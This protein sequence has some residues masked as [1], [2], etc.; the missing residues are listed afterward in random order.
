MDSRRIAI[1]VS[2]WFPVPPQGY[3]GIEL[4]AYNLGRELSSRGHHVTI[5]G[6][7]G[8]QGPYE[9]L[10]L[11]PES[12][13]RQLGTRDEL[14]RENLFLY[15]AYETVRRR[16]FDVI[17]DNSGMNGILVAAQSR[18]Q[19]P[20]VAT[21]HGALSE[22]EGDFLNAVDRQVHLVSIS[23]AQ[24]ALV[25]SVEWRGM[26]HNAINPEEYT[27]ITKPEEKQDYLVELARISPEKGQDVA[28]EIAKRLRMPLV[29]AGK[30]DYDARRYRFEARTNQ[31]TANL[32]EVQVHRS[33]ANSDAHV[34]RSG[35][36][37]FGMLGAQ[38][39]VAIGSIALAARR[40]SLLWLLASAAGIAAIG[41]SAWVYLSM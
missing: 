31:N 6:R 7:Q 23:R 8:S 12:W 14:A 37:F 20:V 19:A 40:K 28:I 33:S 2:P 15:R 11:A 38:C 36:F 32:Y 10:A 29:L 35:F 26:V 3:G 9:S 16:A 18:L 41:F 13:T 30:V 5:I 4:M 24:Q 22:A 21:L 1:I 34:K 17:H 25:A 27:P 39:G